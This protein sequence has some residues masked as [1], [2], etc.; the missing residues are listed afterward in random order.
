[1]YSDFDDFEKSRNCNAK[2]RDVVGED[3]NKTHGYWI[4]DENLVVENNFIKDQFVK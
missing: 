2:L 3:S 1:M 4:G